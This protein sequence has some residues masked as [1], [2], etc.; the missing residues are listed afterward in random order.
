MGGGGQAS[1]DGAYG[2]A[3]MGQT[4]RSVF[5]E[6]AE[7]GKTKARDIAEQQKS[8]GASRLDT[9]ASAV[10][11]AAKNIQ[12]DMPKAAEYIN[13]VADRLADVSSTLRE[14]RVEDLFGQLGE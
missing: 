1:G 7:A 6:A 9:L 8:A 4:T 3:Q 13:D 10:Q 5:G 11:D 14:R 12:S 2:S